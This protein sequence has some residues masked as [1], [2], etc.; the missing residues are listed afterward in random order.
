MII[1]WVPFCTIFFVHGLQKKSFLPL[2][3]RK[4]IFIKII[5]K[6]P[7]EPLFPIPRYTYLLNTSTMPVLR[8]GQTLTLGII[9]LNESNRWLSL[10]LRVATTISRL[11]LR[12]YNSKLSTQSV[13]NMK[14]HNNLWNQ[15][16]NNLS[17]ILNLPPSP[18]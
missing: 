17:K 15:N 13:I 11:I 16:N 9:Q 8:Y 10:M 5:W 2:R 4:M 14:V 7:S 6:I 3:K 1:R 12:N 18:M